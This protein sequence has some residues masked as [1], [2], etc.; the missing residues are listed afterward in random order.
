MKVMQE[1]SKP[2][3][4]KSIP[5]TRYLEKASLK[6]TQQGRYL[7]NASLDTMQ[8]QVRLLM[9]PSFKFLVVHLNTGQQLNDQMETADEWCPSGVCT[10]T[11]TV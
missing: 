2:L 1:S 3:L 5:N 8:T 6:H 11:S 7:E 4:G 10:G 9:P